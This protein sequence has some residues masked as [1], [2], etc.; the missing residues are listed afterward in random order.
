MTDAI[1]EY[2]RLAQLLTK[3]EDIDSGQMFGKPCLKVRGKA[4]MAQHKESVIFKLAGQHHKKAMSIAGAVLW[5]P[6]GKGRPMKEWVALPVDS[7]AQFA[8]LSKA[9]LAY[10]SESAGDAS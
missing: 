9:A 2:E 5:D 8:A 4:F 6:S 1:S 3:T 7:R 10:V